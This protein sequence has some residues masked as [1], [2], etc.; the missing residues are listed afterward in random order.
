MSEVV[1]VFLV[2]ITGQV[3]SGHFPESDS[4]YLRVFWVCGSDW[5]VTAGQEEGLSQVATKS[6][7]REGR[8]VWNFPL[9]ISLKSTTPC[10]WPQLVLAV[11]GP[12]LLGNDVVRGYGSVHA[13]LSTGRGASVRYQYAESKSCG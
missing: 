5:E 1:G 2:S 12:D 8:I 10:G 6:Q 4:L 13:P 11:Y 3:E 7:D 9:N